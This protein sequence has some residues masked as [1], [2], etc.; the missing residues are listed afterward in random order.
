MIAEARPTPFPNAALPARHRLLGP[1]C[2][3]EGLVLGPTADLDRPVYQMVETVD[4]D[5]AKDLGFDP[6]F[7]FVPLDPAPHFPSAAQATAAVARVSQSLALAAN[8]RRGCVQYLVELARYPTIADE[9]ES[10]QRL[11]NLEQARMA[12]KLAQTLTCIA[13]DTCVTPQRPGKREIV[14]QTCLRLSLLVPRL[15]EKDFTEALALARKLSLPQDLILTATRGNRLDSF[16]I[17][18]IFRT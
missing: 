8:N 7:A 3:L 11:H 10:A 16:P 13:V 14:G 15:R 12:T 5:E 6:G 2:R 18:D 9:A 1:P 17:R 4:T